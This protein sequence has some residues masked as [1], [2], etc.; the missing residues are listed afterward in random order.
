MVDVIMPPTIGAAMGFITSEPTPVSRRIGTSANST[1]SAVQRRRVYGKEPLSDVA[2]KAAI[3][4]PGLPRQKNPARVLLKPDVSFA[5]HRC[6]W[7]FSVALV[8]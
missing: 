3:A 2:E 1:S 5:S 6:Y 8:E 4:G 7:T